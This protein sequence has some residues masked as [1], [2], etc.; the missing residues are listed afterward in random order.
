M[1]ADGHRAVG[2]ASSGSELC[3]GALM[4]SPLLLCVAALLP[5]PPLGAWPAV[6]GAVW[7]ARPVGKA[8]RAPSPRAA[9]EAAEGGNAGSDGRGGVVPAVLHE[10]M[11]ESYMAYAMSV[12]MSRALPDARDGLKP[13]HRRIL[14]AMHE[15]GLQPDSPHRKCA[16]VVGEVLGKYH[17]HGDSSVYEAL[18]RMAQDFSLRAPLVDGHGNFGSIDPDPPAAMRYTECRLAALA[19]DT[20]LAD[21]ALD[22]VEFADNFDGSEREPT[23]LPAKLPMLLLN[24]AAG[25]AV[26]M[27]TNC[28][29]HNLGE[30]IDAL[31]A[32]LNGSPTDEELVSHVIA[33]DFPSG[34][35]ILG[36]GGARQMYATGRGTIVVRARTHVE[37]LT[38]SRGA[39]REA[40]VV[41]ELP[42]GAAKNAL[43]EKVATLV[44]EKKLS[45]VADIRDESS[46]E[47]LRI[48]FEANPSPL[49]RHPSRP[50][51]P[52]RRHPPLPPHRRHHPP[53]LAPRRR[54]PC[55][56][57]PSLPSRT[58]S[59][60]H[61]PSARDPHRS[62]ATPTPSSSSTTCTSAPSCRRTSPPI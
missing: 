31:Q 51:S 36:L 52:P 40:I 59:V 56:H 44:N 9:D 20:L 18:V 24:G 11:R 15:L 42:Y 32:L 33:P 58:R 21:V 34:G 41:T 7:P 57:S 48:I 54:P 12:I 3:A 53:R 10:E 45:G 60:R 5:A 1:A 27:A 6:R 46:M 62:V 55:A 16:R 22:T 8:P 49:R 19:R 4:T 28:P 26:G 23:V 17:P 30:L 43:L 13:V 29:P 37:S 35:V 38:K 50:L 39:A 2:T 61:P 25:I 14:Y 47:G